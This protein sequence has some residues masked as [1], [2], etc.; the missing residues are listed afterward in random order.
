METAW[1]DVAKREGSSV[2]KRG[3]AMLQAVRTSAVDWKTEDHGFRRIGILQK[4]NERLRS[5]HAGLNERQQASFADLEESMLFS[6]FTVT[7][8]RG[9]WRV[10]FLVTVTV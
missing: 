10:E 6:G 9:Y 4:L 7:E 2:T 1:V 3:G 8:R 5:V